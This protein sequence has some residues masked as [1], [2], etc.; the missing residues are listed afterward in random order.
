MREN[1]TKVLERDQKLGD[2]ED[3]SGAGGRL[4]GIFV[5]RGF[6]P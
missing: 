6:L 3:K 2:L 5:E 1:V 4:D